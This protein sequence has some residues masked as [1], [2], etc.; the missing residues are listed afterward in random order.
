MR[1]GLRCLSPITQDSFSCGSSG[2][3]RPLRPH[4]LP[5]FGGGRGRCS[6]DRPLLELVRRSSHW[7]GG[8]SE[9]GR[10]APGMR[11]VS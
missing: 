6:V 5:S 10:A 4:D 9:G 1:R 8:Y 7:G 11:V 3:G 2:P